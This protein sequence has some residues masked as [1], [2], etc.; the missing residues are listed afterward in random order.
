MKFRET[1]MFILLYVCY[2]LFV[3]VSERRAGK[4]AATA[5][6]VAPLPIASLHPCPLPPCT[7]CVIHPLAM[8]WL[9]WSV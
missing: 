3:V 9:L 8:S 6:Y 1:V 2:V 4:V 7:P 5:T